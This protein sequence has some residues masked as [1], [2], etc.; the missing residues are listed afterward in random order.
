MVYSLFGYPV[1][2]VEPF[3]E[4]LTFLLR[5]GTIVLSFTQ[6]GDPTMTASGLRAW[7]PSPNEIVL[8]ME[9]DTF[10]QHEV[11]VTRCKLKGSSILQT[12]E[13]IMY[14]SH[15]GRFIGT[16]RTSGHFRKLDADAQ[17]RWDKAWADYNARHGQVNLGTF[18]APAEK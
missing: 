16:M 8:R 15:S 10:N 4:G 17:E 18:E 2:R 12:E 14:D 5:N 7:A 1:Q 9:F 13:T 6:M 3:P 11:E